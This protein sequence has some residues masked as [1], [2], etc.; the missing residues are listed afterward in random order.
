MYQTDMYAW[1]FFVRFCRLHYVHPT[2]NDLEL[3]QAIWNQ[4]IPKPE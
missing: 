1:V 3:K 4:E 2:A